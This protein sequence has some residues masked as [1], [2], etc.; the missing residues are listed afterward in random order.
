MGSVEGAPGSASYFSNIGADVRP[1]AHAS[2]DSSF[3]PIAPLPPGVFALGLT[4]APSSNVLCYWLVCLDHVM[5]VTV[6]S[7]LSLPPVVSGHCEIIAVLA[8]VIMLCLLSWEP[9]HILS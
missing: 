8:M 3:H 4:V 2:V 5:R 9:F 6:R 7:L 1:F